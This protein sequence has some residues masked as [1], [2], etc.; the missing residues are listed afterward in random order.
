MGGVE[1]AKAGFARSVAADV[2]F[3]ADVGGGFFLDVKTAA[4]RAGPTANLL[5]GYSRRRGGGWMV[6]RDGGGKCITIHGQCAPCGQAVGIGCGHDQP[7][8]GAHFPMQ[9]PHRILFIII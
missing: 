4:G 6:S 3:S 5:G 1:F 8:G 2:A 9:K 7:T